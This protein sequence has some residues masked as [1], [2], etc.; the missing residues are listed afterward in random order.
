MSV[1]GKRKRDAGAPA[2]AH[3]ASFGNSK[4]AAHKGGKVVTNV[5]VKQVRSNPFETVKQR[6]KFAVLGRKLKGT[7]RETGQARSR[8]IQKRKESLLVEL[9]Q[10]L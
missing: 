6:S 2:P 7:E 9:Q 3:R 8:A 5:S 10:V 4:K 1:T